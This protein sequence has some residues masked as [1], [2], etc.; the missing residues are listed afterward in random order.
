MN[1]HPISPAFPVGALTVALALVFLGINGATQAQVTPGT[2]GTTGVPPGQG[3][4]VIGQ[5]P[6]APGGS[7]IGQPTPGGH[8]DTLPQ[9]STG[10]SRI[11]QPPPGLGGYGST[12]GSDP[13]RDKLNRTN[14]EAADIDRDGRLSPEEAARIPPGTPLPR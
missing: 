10:G 8:T 11:G 9:Q 4:S 5:P 13:V 1:F 6:Q 3:S 12:P 7:I 2:G 14:R